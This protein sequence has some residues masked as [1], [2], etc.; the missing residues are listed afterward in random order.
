MTDQLEP[1]KMTTPGEWIVTTTAEGFVNVV[2][3]NGKTMKQKTI[4]VIGKIEL[5]KAN[6]Y[7]SVDESEILANAALIAVSKDM[8]DLLVEIF[9][10]L[11]T[12]KEVIDLVELNDQY[13]AIINKLANEAGEER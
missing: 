2:A 8:L 1:T 10:E 11:N 5:E 4:A 7:V 13:D 12:S 9:V 6:C 3:V